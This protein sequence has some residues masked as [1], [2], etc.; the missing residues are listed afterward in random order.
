V[1]DPPWIE[2]I[3]RGYVPKTGPCLFGAGGEGRHQP[4]CI[5]SRGVRFVPRPAA[6][7]ELLAKIMPRREL[8]FPFAGSRGRGSHHGRCLRA[9]P[10]MGPRTGRCVAWRQRAADRLAGVCKVAG[11]VVSMQ[12][13]AAD[14]CLSGGN[15]ATRPASEGS[16]PRAR[17]Q[18]GRFPSG[19]FRTA[20]RPRK[21]IPS[22]YS[23]SGREV[24]WK[25]VISR[26]PVASAAARPIIRSSAPNAQG[27][28]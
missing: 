5:S 12:P 26:L 13:R 19:P 25:Q 14:E 15:Q 2:T 6:R 17:L 28:L 22:V 11:I 10:R 27:G 23:V 21:R 9:G 18:A 3:L 1:S 4:S 16:K 7:T 8:D 24:S 20:S